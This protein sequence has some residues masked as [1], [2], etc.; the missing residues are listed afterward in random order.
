MSYYKILHTKQHLL[1]DISEC[2]RVV[3]NYTPC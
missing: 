1:N 2:K 3:V